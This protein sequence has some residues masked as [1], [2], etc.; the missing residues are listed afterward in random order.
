M[1]RR[2]RIIRNIAIGLAALIVVLVAA[3]LIVVHTDRFQNYVREK[4]ITALQEGTGGKTEIGSFNFDAA[5][6][7]ARITNLVIHGSEPA[8]SAPFAR[9]ASI[10]LQARLFGGS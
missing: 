2:V 5:H 4:I 9:V 8:G 3:A 1:S 10:D 6:L 7:R